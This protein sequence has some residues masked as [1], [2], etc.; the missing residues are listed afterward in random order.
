MVSELLVD[1]FLLAELFLILLYLLLKLL[2]LLS[3]ELILL[4]LILILPVQLLNLL[5]VELVLLVMDP[6]LLVV[7]VHS[8]L[9]TPNGLIPVSNV[10]LQFFD[11]FCLLILVL[12]EVLNIVEEPHLALYAQ[13]LLGFLHLVVETLFGVGQVALVD[14]EDKIFD[15]QI[16]EVLVEKPSEKHDDG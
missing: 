1:L 5:V 16:V 10:K 14:S 3:V 9:N 15:H 2:N 12:T 7:A 4:V 11:D 13:D 8:L 6:D